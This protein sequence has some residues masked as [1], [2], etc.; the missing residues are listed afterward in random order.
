MTI[1]TVRVDPRGMHN[2]WVHLPIGSMCPD[3]DG[4][5]LN[6]YFW[7]PSVDLAEPT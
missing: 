3:L 4:S 5:T 1:S 6:L 2:P 7:D